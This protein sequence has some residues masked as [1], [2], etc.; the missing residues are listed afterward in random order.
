ALELP[1]EAVAV[2]GYPPVAAALVELARL[3]EVAADHVARLQHG[4]QPAAAV[5]RGLVAGLPEEGG[6][7]RH[8]PHHPPPAQEELPQLHTAARIGPGA[9]VAQQGR[10][11]DEVRLH[12]A[13]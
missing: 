12:A 4:G 11:L 10:G 13:A 6:A 8:V 3:L 2:L 9:G 7:A 1:G 5:Q